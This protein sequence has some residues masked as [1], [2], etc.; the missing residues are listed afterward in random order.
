MVLKLRRLDTEYI[1]W[2]FIS[3]VSIGAVLLLIY[4]ASTI[5]DEPQ[6]K[7]K[8][9][10]KVKV[11][12]VDNYAKVVYAPDKDTVLFIFTTW[13]GHC[14]NF[15]PHYMDIAEKLSGEADLQFAAIQPRD[16][17][18]IAGTKLDT[19][20]F[21]VFYLFLR[22]QKDTPIKFYDQTNGKSVEEFV[23]EARK[24]RAQMDK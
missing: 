12:D 24:H 5:K 14:L 10:S 4:L 9:E 2:L 15:I 22:G 3:F 11:L 18:K 21:P 13:C 17:P 16:M 20:S 8:N 6:I 23:S 19:S 1:S 7:M